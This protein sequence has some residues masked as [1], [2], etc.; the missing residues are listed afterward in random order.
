MTDPTR[1][2]A[3]GDA[4]PDFVLP[5]TDG[6]RWSYADAAGPNGLVVMFICNHCPYVK[7]VVD[8]IVQDAKSLRDIGVGAVAICSNDADAYPEDSFERM[9]A[10]AQRH[11][12]GFPYLHDAAQAVARAYGAV[13]TPEFYGFDRDRVLRYHGRL[14]ASGR[15]PAGPGTRRELVEAMRQWVRTGRAPDEQLPSIGCSIKW[16]QA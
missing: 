1:T 4:A 9:A 15:Q 2:L 8:R 12:F 5:A 10:F 16:K 3:R 11:G 6:R 13:C 7:A 14:D